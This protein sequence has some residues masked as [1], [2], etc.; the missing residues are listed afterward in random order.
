MS[1]EERVAGAGRTPLDELRSLQIE[2]RPV[3]SQKSRGP[4]IPWGWLIAIGVIVAAVVFLREPV[5]RW[6][7]EQTTPPLDTGIVVRTGGQQVLLTGSGYVNADAVVIVGTTIPGRVRTIAVDKGDR[8]KKGQ[9]IVQ[10]EDDE[11]R[12]E[13]GVQHANLARD[14]RNLTRQE[15]LAKSQATTQQAVDDMRSAVEADRAAIQLIDAKL[16]QTRLQSPIEGKVI[17]RMVEPGDIVS[18]MVGG[19][20]GVVKLADL[21]KTVVEVDVNEA[22]IGKLKLNQPAEVRLDAFP[23]RPYEAKLAE[24]AQVADKA[25]ATVQVKVMLS[26]PDDDVRPGMNAKVTFRPL[27]GMAEP[28]RL[29]MPKKALVGGQ[30]FVYTV[31]DGHIWRRDVQTRSLSGRDAD[32]VEVLSGLAEGETVVVSGQDKLQPGQK[33]PT[34]KD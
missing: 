32:M 12:A 5:K 6:Y 19:M 9:L 23:D 7:A 33:A 4:R 25:K 20:G 2:R 24:F 22:D 17:E 29:L 16:K 3:R 14:S 27:A 15:Q 21:R 34:K 26:N 30:P 10:L 8:V 18:P 28:E 1:T 11:L 31:R 13:L